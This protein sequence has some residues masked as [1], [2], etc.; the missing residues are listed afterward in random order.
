MGSVIAVALLLIVSSVVVRAATLAPPRTSDVPELSTP[1]GASPTIEQ[2]SLGR[3]FISVS[4]RGCCSYAGHDSGQ[5]GLSQGQALEAAYSPPRPRWCGPIAAPRRRGRGPDAPFYALVRERSGPYDVDR[6]A[7]LEVNWWAVHRQPPSVP[8]RRRWL[9]RCRLYAEIYRPAH[10][11]GATGR[12]TRARQWTCPTSGSARARR[13]TALCPAIRRE[14][15]RLHP[16][17]ADALVAR[18]ARP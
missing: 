9:K 2:A 17:A 3:L 5:L 12:R 15:D 18:S 13:A 7:N 14:L 8:D 1:P 6:A 4:G 11:G 16:G 10:G